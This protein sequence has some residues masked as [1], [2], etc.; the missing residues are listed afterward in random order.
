M[1]GYLVRFSTTISLVVRVDDADLPDHL[2]DDHEE[3]AAEYAWDRAEE[4]LQSLGATAPALIADA[5]LDGKGEDSIERD[6]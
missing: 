4:F 5:T 3:A 6:Y 2:I 1:P